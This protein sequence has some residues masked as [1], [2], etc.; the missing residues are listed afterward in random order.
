[1]KLD[2]TYLGM[3][4]RRPSVRDAVPWSALSIDKIEQLAEI[5]AETRKWREA[6]G[7]GSLV[8]LYGNIR[9]GRR[10]EP[11]SLEPGNYIA[12]IGDMHPAK[13]AFPI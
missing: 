4:L 8:N 2:T 9:K 7:Y 6:G 1:M 5:E 11:S 13:R 12:E 10:S 3:F